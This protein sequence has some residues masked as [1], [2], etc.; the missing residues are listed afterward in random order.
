MT[1]PDTSTYFMIAL[2]RW[3]TVGEGEGEKSKSRRDSKS[4]GFHWASASGA[5]QAGATLSGTHVFSA[6]REACTFL[7]ATALFRPHDSN[8]LLAFV[9]SFKKYE[10]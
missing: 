4:F 5:T 7:K 6:P 10:V 8:W 9:A 1:P 2:C 3:D